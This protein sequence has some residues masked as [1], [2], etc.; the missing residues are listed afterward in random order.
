MPCTS[1]YSTPSNSFTTREFNDLKQR[2]DDATRA[3]CTAMT[4]ICSHEP[5]FDNK[6]EDDEDVLSRAVSY[7]RVKKDDALHAVAWIK[8]HTEADKARKQALIESAKSKLTDEEKEALCL[9]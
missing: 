4:A 5:R 1:D 2:L 3:A 6:L 9:K 8:T 7:N